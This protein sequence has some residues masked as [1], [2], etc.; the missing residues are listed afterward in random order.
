MRLT[1]EGTQGEIV[2]LVRALGDSELLLTNSDDL[3][4]SPLKRLVT[5]PG[6]ATNEAGQATSLSDPVAEAER[7]RRESTIK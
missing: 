1:I 5:P 7:I 4:L 2:R 6:T 3:D